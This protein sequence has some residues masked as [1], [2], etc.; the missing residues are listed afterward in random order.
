MAPTGGNEWVK[1]YL[2]MDYQFTE[3]KPL[4]GFAISTT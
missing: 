4:D 2:I 3:N 1:H